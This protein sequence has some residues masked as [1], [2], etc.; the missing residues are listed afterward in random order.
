MQ[1]AVQNV[2]RNKITLTQYKALPGKVYALL[3]ASDQYIMT[4]FQFV[5]TFVS[6]LT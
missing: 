6:K 2:K 3:H 5:D 4:I 1:Q